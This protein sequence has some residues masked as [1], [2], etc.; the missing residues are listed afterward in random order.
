[1]KSRIHKNRGIYSI[2]AALLVGITGVQLFFITG[3]TANEVSQAEYSEALLAQLDFDSRLAPP[4]EATPAEKIFFNTCL[5]NGTFQRVTA[6]GRDVVAH[7]N[8]LEKLHD[9]DFEVIVFRARDCRT[10]VYDNREKQD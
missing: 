3:V 5:T 7:G 4:R 8:N 10:E 6:R 1:M 2:A 9:K